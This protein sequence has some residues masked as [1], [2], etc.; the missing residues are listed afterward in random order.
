MALNK[1]MDSR[2]A[3]GWGQL[4]IYAIIALVIL[5]IFLNVGKIFK[6]GTGF[7]TNFFSDKTATDQVPVIQEQVVD[8]VKKLLV[9]NKCTKDDAWFTSTALKLE[10]AMQGW[11]SDRG[12]ISPLIYAL[13]SDDDARALYIA[14]GVRINTDGN[15]E[16]GDLTQ[17]FG[18]EFSNLPEW[19]GGSSNMVSLIKDKFQNSGIPLPW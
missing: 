11:G 3:K 6:F 2:E 10:Q 16:A 18:W 7:L 12:T 14:F 1:N 4:V 17:W 13:N 15:N 5:P 19:L 8:P 9:K